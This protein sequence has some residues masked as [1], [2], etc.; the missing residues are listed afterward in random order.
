M[1]R[2]LLSLL[3]LMGLALT[4]GAQGQ[5]VS[6]RF[7]SDGDPVAHKKEVTAIV[8]GQRTII[9][10]QGD[11]SEYLIPVGANV[12]L[13]LTAADG[14]VDYLWFDGD[15]EIS[16][17]YNLKSYEI[18]NLTTSKTIRV[19]CRKLIP[20]KFI[21]PAE[22]SKGKEV[23]IDEQDDYGTVIAPEADG[24][25]YMLPLQ[26][27]VYFDSGVDDN[28][29]VLRWLLNG[30][31]TFPGKPDIFFK[32]NVPEG[33]ELE[34]QFY[35][36][37]ETRT[38]TY[39]QPSTAIIRCK[40]RGQYDSPEIESGSTVDPGDEILFEIAPPDNPSGKVELHH[41]EVNGE[42]YMLGEEYYTDNSLSIYA[43]TDLDVTAVP[44]EEYEAPE[45]H[46]NLSAEQVDFGSVAIGETKSQSVTLTTEG[47]TMPVL[48]GLRDA[49]PSLSFTPERLPS[50]GGEITITFAPTRREAVSTEL[51][52]KSGETIVALPIIA[53][54]TTALDTPSSETLPYRIQQSEIVWLEEVVAT[55]YTADGRLLS[56]GT[57]SA[58]SV[59]R[60][61]ASG[62][63][64]VELQNHRYKVIVR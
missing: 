54:G 6:L 16:R 4:C 14:Y 28:H 50:S 61:P 18:Q 51:L 27:S 38:V 5:K 64:F 44:M 13:Q 32:Q 55:I 15:K 7:L 26:G 57:Y 53:Q 41:W 37:G 25:T 34:V 63:Y 21:C 2:S 17:S 33:F 10:P 36:A 43:F 23:N 19:D 59:F 3:L 46:L 12:E 1:K 56:T 35:K 20:V 45:I 39:T 22:G 31:A 8:S 62:V 52:L 48:L 40:N 24:D 30:G 49:V 29:F 47:A 11:G 42:P 58:G 60:L 9:T